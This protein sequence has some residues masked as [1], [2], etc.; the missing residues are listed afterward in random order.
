MKKKQNTNDISTCGHFN[1]YQF[2]F[3]DGNNQKNNL[4]EEFRIE[5]YSQK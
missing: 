1:G 2:Y 4:V 3:I 5:I